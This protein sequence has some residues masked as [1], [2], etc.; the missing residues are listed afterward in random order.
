[1]TGISSLSRKSSVKRRQ[2][3]GGRDESLAVNIPGKKVP[4]MVPLKTPL[5]IERPQS[6]TVFQSSA[7]FEFG[8]Q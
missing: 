8:P 1:M 4:T 5:S 6:S 3:I 7:A 2:T